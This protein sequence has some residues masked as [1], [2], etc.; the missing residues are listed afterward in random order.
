MSAHNRPLP[1][2]LS[3][4]AQADF[5]DIRVY[6]LRR[7]DEAQWARYR[8]A[9]DRALRLL[10]DNPEIGRAR[11]DLRPGYRA[12]LVEQHIILY[13]VATGAV[14]VARIVHRRMDTQRALQRRR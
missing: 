14:R 7:W 6:T 8:T 12:Y 4:A 5:E 13:R 3:A 1:V 10:G 2:V 11:E 9:L